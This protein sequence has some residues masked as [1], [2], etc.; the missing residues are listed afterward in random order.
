MR[1]SPSQ[2]EPWPQ[3]PVKFILPL[4]PGAGVD[5]TARLVA[6]RLAKRWDQPVV[7]EN[8]PGGDGMVAITAFIGA[9]DN[10]TLLFSPAGSFTAHPYLHE[11]LPY[12]PRELAPIARVT[13]RWLRS[14]CR[15]AVATLTDLIA[16]ARAQRA[17]STG[18]PRPTNGSL[19]R[20]PEDGRLSMQRVPHRDTVR[21]STT[22][23]D[24]CMWRW[25]SCFRRFAPAR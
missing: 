7:V 14:A 20:F 9:H 4:G 17:S 22:P 24:A 12:D 23:R 6:D 13:T 15:V 18:R 16:M 3:R 8:R 1:S 5:V 2:A 19:R 25:P 21:R 10:H 11:K